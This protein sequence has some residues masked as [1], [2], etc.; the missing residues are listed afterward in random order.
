MD[1]SSSV[2]AVLAKKELVALSFF[3]M[4]SVCHGLRV[5]VLGVIGMFFCLFV[6]CLFF[7]E[8]GHF[9]KMWCLGERRS[10]A[11]IKG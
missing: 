8:C 4:C 2:I 10:S 7:C 5:L 3:G 1:L 11:V 6:F 9:F